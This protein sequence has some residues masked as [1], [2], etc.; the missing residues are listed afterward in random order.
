MSDITKSKS[1]RALAAQGAEMKNRHLNDLFRA[2]PDR[3]AKFSIEMQD[4]LFDYSKNLVTEQTIDGLLDLARE[5]DVEAWRARMFSGAQVNMTEDRA[6]LH[7]A[8]RNRSNEPI[9]VDGADVMPQIKAEL[10]AMKSF[11]ERVRGGDWRGYSGKRITDVV[12]IG[13][14]GSHL[15]PQMVTEALKGSKNNPMRVHYISNVDGTQIADVLRP[16]NPEQVLFV[17]SS[18]T[19]TTYETLTNMRTAMN[20]LVASSFDQSVLDKHFV[21]V[22]AR[23]ENA[24]KEGFPA[25]NIFQIWDWVGGRFS[26]WSAIGL[27]IA[28]YLGFDSFEELLDGA[29]DMDQHF[30]NAPLG[31]NAPVMLALIGVWNSTFLEAQTQAILPYDQSLHM[32]SAYMQQ[33]EME[34]NGKSVNWDGADVPY[35]TGAII[36][37]QLGINGQH[38]FYQYLHQGKNIVPCDF[39]GSIESN[40]PVKGHHEYLMANFFAQTQALM[41]GIDEEE[42]RAELRRKGKSERYIE[43]L[44]SHKIHKGNRPTNTLLLSRISPRTLGSLIALYEHKIFVQGI[45]W[46]VCSFDQWGVELGKQLAMNIQGELAPKAATG[47]HDSSTTGLIDYFKQQRDTPPPPSSRT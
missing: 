6:V 21:A 7:V 23:P 9:L 17:I 14:G 11:V 18:K 41:I 34:S 16:L 44:V 28:L 20:W 3:F 19:F 43:R 38:A 10:A 25:E 47:P 31:E 5:V 30:Q 46:Q 26:L 24:E 22:T 37:G 1:W 36:W 13:I 15:G 35:Q 2:D 29:H 33:A 27:P 12:S 45:I 32:F 8:L 42:V 4:I 40:T 39:I